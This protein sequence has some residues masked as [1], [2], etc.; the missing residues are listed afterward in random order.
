MSDL[1][2]ELTLTLNRAENYVFTTT[3]KINGDITSVQCIMR[4]VN[5][6]HSVVCE[7][8]NSCIQNIHIYIV[9][10][11]CITYNHG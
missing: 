9:R 11:S 5:K 3:N 4:L 2:I 6:V 7:Q 10:R 8:N 1:F